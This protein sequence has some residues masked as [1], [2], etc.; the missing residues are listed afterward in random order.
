MHFKLKTLIFTAVFFLVL[1]HLLA[2]S[3][4]LLLGDGVRGSGNTGGS[5]SI[6]LN[7]SQPVVGVQLTLVNQP[8]YLSVVNVHNGDRTNTVFNIIDF[9][10]I[11]N[12]TTTIIALCT[13][14]CS[15]LESGEGEILKID[16][17]LSVVAPPGKVDLLAIELFLVDP[18]GQLIPTIRR[19]G[20]FFDPQVTNF[21]EVSKEAGFDEL[22]NTMN[23]AAFGF[24]WAD[25]NNDG[26]EDLLY[27]GYSPTLLHNNADGTF[28]NV[29]ESSGV[30]TEIPQTASFNACG[31]A[32]WGDYDNDG[33]PDA[34]ILAQFGGRVLL[35]NNGDSTFTDATASANL[36]VESE[37]AFS[38]NWVDFNNDGHLDL[39]TSDGFLFKNNGD[40]T[41]SEVSEESDI[42]SAPFSGTA[43][44]DF[45]NDGDADLFTHDQ[46]FR[47]DN[48]AFIDVT[49]STGIILGGSIASGMAW[50]DYN[51]DEYLDLFICRGSFLPTN[52]YRNNG[53]ETFTDVAE[54]A[55]VAIENA[56][57]V[58]WADM[59]NDGELEKNRCKY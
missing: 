3:D 31:S 48:G 9:H 34:F 14:T 41:F 18:N 16:F 52:L 5:I 29:G 24:A 47:N 42:G 21:H 1:Q 22:Y 2:Q 49:N 11:S 38:V 44:A 19:N 51:N 6:L 28:T 39:Y 58:A 33:D 26:N 7:N 46:Q 35:E 17:D 30:S 8:A 56:I 23:P 15:I 13:D 37:S 45:D 4:T 50:G 54:S 12:D 36:I 59:D 55:G 25:Y 57:S 10:N 40:K 20:T 53:D 27:F 32:S 43:W